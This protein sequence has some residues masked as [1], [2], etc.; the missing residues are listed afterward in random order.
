MDYTEVEDLF[1]KLEGLTFKS[2][3]DILV[4]V[5]ILG[6]DDTQIDSNWCDIYPDYDFPYY[7]GSVCFYVEDE[8]HN[9]DFDVLFESNF[10]NNVIKSVKLQQVLPI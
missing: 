9:Y 7:S 8:F 6:F 1:L 2:S 5:M 4:N 10:D 3:L